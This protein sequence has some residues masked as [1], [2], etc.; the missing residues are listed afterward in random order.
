MPEPK[1]L[2]PVLQEFLDHWPTDLLLAQQ[3]SLAAEIAKQEE[4]GDG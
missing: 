1:P 3:I 2:H 4:E